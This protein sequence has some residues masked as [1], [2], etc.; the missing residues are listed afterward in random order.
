MR[1]LVL[2]L[3][4]LPQPS[5]DN[6]V[7]GR[8]A[9]LLQTL[10]NLLAETVKERFVYLWGAPGSGKSHLLKATVD[11]FRARHSS[12]SH[13]PCGAAT[14]FSPGLDRLDCVALDDVHDLDGAGQ[15]ALFNLYNHMR[16]GLG[17][18]LV[19]GSAAP[20]RLGLREDLV[21]RLSWG[22]VYRVHGLSDAEKVEALKRHA[23]GRGFDLPGELA[24]YLLRHERRDLPT[25][26]AV[27][28]ALDRHSL[29]TKR[30]VTV[31]LLRE[32]LQSQAETAPDQ[33]PRR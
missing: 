7:A 16:E 27:L 4:R 2:D 19:S 17:V 33:R 22:L 6:F 15:L 26:V 18:L 1:Q 29:E 3:S 11:A 25:L 21:T 28:D 12:A 32:V 30:P 14:G 5:L 8:N 20:S 31:S 10:R 24:E 13:I 9:E 23:A